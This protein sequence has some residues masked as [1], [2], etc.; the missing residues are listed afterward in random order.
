MRSLVRSVLVTLALFAISR[1]A[2]AAPP[3]T[4][5]AH[6]AI[7]DSGEFSATVI[8]SGDPTR[9]WVRTGDGSLELTLAYFGPDRFHYEIKRNGERAF[10]MSG[11]VTPP[12]GKPLV[13]GSFPSAQDVKLWL[14][15]R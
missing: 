1:F 5:V 6:V 2:H 12:T 3:Q 10:S 15:D 4:L 11:V 7:A 9:L 14:T 13:L 8:K